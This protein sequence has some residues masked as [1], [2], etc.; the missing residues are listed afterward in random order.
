ML[1]NAIQIGDKVDISALPNAENTGSGSEAVRVYKSKVLDQKKDG[2]L[3]L[4]M[5]MEQGKVI[6]LS[7]G[8]RYEFVFYINN[9][10][11]KSMGQV[12]E[13]YKKNNIYI[14][15]VR[16]QTQLQKYQ[17]R[18]YYRFPCLIET[19]F[20]P[21]KTKDIKTL[22]EESIMNGAVDCGDPLLKTAMILDLSGGGAR[23]ISDERLENNS[24]IIMSL[25]LVSEEERKKYFISG[26]VLSSDSIIDQKSKFENRIMFHLKDDLI[27]EEIIRY[28]FNEE[29]KNR[30]QKG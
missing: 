23:M 7:L 13:R 5:P 24:Y 28:I 3:E 12:V 6:L 14:V 4:L 26:T 11:Y 9:N 1:T 21:V 8:V 20:L 10:L 30:S 19:R 2:T 17:R 29:R 22:D 16:L 25:D 18:E 27:R 15:Y